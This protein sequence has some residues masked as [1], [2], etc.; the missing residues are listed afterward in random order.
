[1]EP[2]EIW[3]D[4]GSVYLG[5]HSRSQS[6]SGTGSGKTTT[7]RVMIRM[8]CRLAYYIHIISYFCNWLT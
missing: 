2:E 4:I 1:M 8:S 6:I 7:P 5:P 3:K